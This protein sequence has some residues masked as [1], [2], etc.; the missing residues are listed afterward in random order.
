MNSY[1][2]KQNNMIIRK[3]VPALTTPLKFIVVYYKIIRM[4]CKKKVTSWS[5]IVLINLSIF[6]LV[7]KTYFLYIL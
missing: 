1:E 2:V 6:L 3:K 5:E 4:N 7:G